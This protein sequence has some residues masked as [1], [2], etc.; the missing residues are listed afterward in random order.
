MYGCI[1]CDM[2]YIV[3]CF[4]YGINLS[5]GLIVYY[6]QSDIVVFGNCYFREDGVFFQFVQFD[7]YC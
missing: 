4:I 7:F 6:I 1:V 3:S 2:V 5:V